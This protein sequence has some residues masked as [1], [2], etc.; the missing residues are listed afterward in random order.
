MP[1]EAWLDNLQMVLREKY[2][3]L[4][5]TPVT[6]SGFFSYGQPKEDVRRSTV[7]VFPVFYEKA[8]FMAMQK[9]STLVVMRATK[10][11]NP[12]QVPVI[13]ADCPLYMQ[14]KKM[15]MEVP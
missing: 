10:F 1:D 5:D 2:G 13:G 9:H 6:Y 15:P 11:V 3:I 8:S 14:Q 7:G 4:Q 12:G